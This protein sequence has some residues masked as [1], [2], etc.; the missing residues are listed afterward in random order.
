MWRAITASIGA[1]FVGC[2]GAAPPAPEQSAAIAP[3]ERAPGALVLPAY[4]EPSVVYERG[5]ERWIVAG[6]VRAIL[7]A[8]GRV[9]VA[10][11]ALLGRITD[12]V[13][14]PDETVVF[15][16][17]LGT[18]AWSRG[19]LGPLE[20]RERE[21]GPWLVVNRAGA[22]PRVTN[23]GRLRAIPLPDD[24]RGLA[25]TPSGAGLAATR[26]GR[27]LRTLS[28]GERWDE[29]P[30]RVE[31]V[32]MHGR[33]EVRVDLDRRTYRLDASGELVERPDERLGPR[34][35]PEEDERR[36]VEAILR[37][38]PELAP[39]VDIAA[40][41]PTIAL[42]ED[43]EPLHVV[44]AGV[45]CPYDEPFALTTGV[46]V[47]HALSAARV[48]ATTH[49]RAPLC[50]ALPSD[51]RITHVLPR[52]DGGLLLRTSGGSVVL[53]SDAGC[54]PLTPLPPQAVGACFIDDARGVAWGS[55]SA[56]WQTADGGRRWAPLAIDRAASALSAA[57]PEVAVVSAER[58]TIAERVVVRWDGG[59]GA[60]VLGPREGE[61]RDRPEC[62]VPEAALLCRLEPP[63]SP[64]RQA[65]RL[66]C[67]AR[68]C[69]ARLGA[70]RVPLGSPTCQQRGAGPQLEVALETEHGV[71]LACDAEGTD[72]C[73]CRAPAIWLPRAGRP[74]DL[75]VP[76]AGVEQLLLLPDASLALLLGAPSGASRALHL[77]PDGRLLAERRADLDG[78][79]GGLL[80]HEGRPALALWSR[81]RGV[82]TLYRLDRSGPPF[83]RRPA[84]VAVPRRTCGV[85]DEGPL[86]VTH[87]TV[88]ELVWEGEPP[89][90]ITGDTT[91]QLRITPEDTCLEQASLRLVDGRAE[92]LPIGPR[93]L[94]G[95]HRSRGAATPMRC[96]LFHDDRGGSE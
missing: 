84:R 36:V 24:T 40:L 28:L 60:R 88:A 17:E 81:E 43:P 29:L 62:R 53:G 31:A 63:A 67:D 78:I 44:P 42:T 48:D 52:G 26:D 66:E 64:D 25:L 38:H 90:E 35:L 85:V 58:C 72:E 56:L 8:E 33:S 11:D 74:V 92:L 21:D 27:L 87:R 4:G 70:L 37:A 13:T 30:G 80:E 61:A 34:R 46:R 41:D 83:E 68:E 69:H 71:L 14:G 57:V 79:S 23:G 89:G 1:L 10:D 7:D 54:G 95:T 55:L 32:Y 39:P 91:F 22:S 47:V 5:G 12:L 94:A 16:D 59:G 20:Q 49:A 73:R 77:G 65:I 19:F 3:G 6:G 86:L 45:G 50:P 82:L 18:I 96:T 76:I 51:A 93:T 2:A 75:Q 15:R 9:R